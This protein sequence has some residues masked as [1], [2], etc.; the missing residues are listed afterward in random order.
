MSI[1]AKLLLC[2]NCPYMLLSFYRLDCNSYEPPYENAQ[3]TYLFI[4]VRQYMVGI[5]SVL[6]SHQLL[7]FISTH[8]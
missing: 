5:S 3:A 7:P 1:N 2:I 6:H 8:L 4:Q